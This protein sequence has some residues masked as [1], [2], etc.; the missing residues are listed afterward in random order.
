[1]P[2]AT[3][4]ILDIAYE[5][6]GAREA[7]PVFLLHGWPDDVR[8]FDRVAPELQRA[9]F[10][11]IAPWLRGFG[12][13]QFLSPAS[14]RSGQIAAMAQDVVDLADAL[15]LAHFAVVGHDW[16]ARIAYILAA[17]APERVGCIAALSVGW[18]PGE[19]RTPPVEQAQRYW[20]QWFMATER[21][22]RFVR[23]NPVAFARFQWETWSPSGWFEDADFARTAAAFENPD[24]SAVTVHS[25]RVRWGEAERDP[26]Y[27][28]LKRRYRDASAIAVP[29]LMIHGGDD[30][31]T[32][33]AS[34]EGKDKYFTGGY[35]RHVVPGVGHFPTREAPEQVA[36]LT[37]KFLAAQPFAAS[38]P[39]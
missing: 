35:A 15:K 31:V 26:A 14:L 38:W 23:E 16:G 30:R 29:S 17:T 25:Y 4:P 21:D 2:R 24:W 34:S 28:P 22:A 27:A 33:P 7:P 20:Y 6:G 13:T 18:E 9:G 1:M 37:L 11:T 19:M 32:L 12:P 3:T 10:R 39:R 8:S 36:A 5:E